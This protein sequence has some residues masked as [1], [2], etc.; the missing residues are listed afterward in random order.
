MDD[1]S[2][3]DHGDQVSPELLDVIARMRWQSARSVE[4]ACCTAPVRRGRLGQGR[5]DR[6]RVLVGG[7]HRS[8][9]RPR[10]GVAGTR[11]F[12]ATPQRRPTYRNTYL[13]LGGYAHWFTSPARRRAELNRELTS[14][15]LK[16]PTRRLPGTGP[17]FT[18]GTPVD[19]QLELF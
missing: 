12:Y 17:A 7:E 19:E 3:P 18:I 1:G 16:T 15:Q 9:R 14:Q 2:F 6:G 11:G 10:G 13:Y 4:I 5:R 8:S